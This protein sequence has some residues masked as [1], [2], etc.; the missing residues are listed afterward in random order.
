[1]V[2]CHW[3]RKRFFV[4][5]RV[6]GALIVRVVLYWLLCLFTMALL[7]LVWRMFSVPI[8]P[9]HTHL[10]ELWSLFGPAA[11][12][13]MLLLPAVVYDL[14]RLSNRFAG[15][16]F[17]LRRVMHDMA[18]G[19]TGEIVRFRDGDFWQELAAD[20]NTVAARLDEANRAG[21][22]PAHD[23]ELAEAGATS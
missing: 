3:L 9:F 18:Q 8:R 6:Q 5:W 12:A 11:V 2:R 20:F 16:M 21:N 19:K 10:T 23:E 7:L 4:D 17:R 15:P 14:V 13:S 1:M 22:P